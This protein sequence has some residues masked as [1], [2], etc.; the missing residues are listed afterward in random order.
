[1]HRIHKSTKQQ[2]I[3]LKILTI[4]NGQ[5]QYTDNGKLLRSNNTSNRQTPTTN[6]V[7]KLKE[8]P[9]CP[10]HAS[11]KQRK[12]MIVGDSHAKGCAAE[13]KHLLSS[14]FKFSEPPTQELE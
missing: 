7:N 12:F 8:Y 6:W 1:M 5:V 10:K 4:V 2:T 3:G 13:V 14:D 9:K 11:Q